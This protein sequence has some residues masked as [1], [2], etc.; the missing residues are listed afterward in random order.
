[1]M[2]KYIG[3]L[4]YIMAIVVGARNI[5]GSVIIFLALAVT[6]LFA[7]R[8]ANV[9]SARLSTSKPNPFLDGIYFF[10]SQILIM[11]VAYL[12]G[13]FASSGGGEMFGMWL[14]NEVLRMG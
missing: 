9:D 5:H 1:M 8:R 7:R 6:L 10:G 14:R 12:L 4:A 11:F 13:Y 3:Y 2:M